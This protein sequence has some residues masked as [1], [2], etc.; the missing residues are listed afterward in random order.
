M[1]I[2]NEWPFNELHASIPQYPSLALLC[3]RSSLLHQRIQFNSKLCKTVWLGLILHTS[4]PSVPRSL[5]FL[6]SALS[7][8]R[9]SGCS[10]NALSSQ[11]ASFARVGSSSFHIPQKQRVVSRQVMDTL[12]RFYTSIMHLFMSFERQPS[13]LNFPHMDV[14][15]LTSDS[16]I[17]ITIWNAQNGP[18]RR[19]GSLNASVSSFR[20]VD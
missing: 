14:D 16:V 13:L 3:Q 12:R 17:I 2:I 15:P 19:F 10:P 9:P 20:F 18:E 7:R 6:V 5:H 1:D 8:Q 11:Y 4:G